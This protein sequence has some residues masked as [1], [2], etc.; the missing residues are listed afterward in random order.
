[1]SIDRMD[2]H[3]TEEYPSDL[4]YENS[5]THIGMYLAWIINN[6]LLSEDLE[7]DCAEE[8]QAVCNRTMTGRD[9]LIDVCDE[10]FLDDDLSEEGL[11]FT[12]SYYNDFDDNSRH[13]FEDYEDVLVKDLP[14]SYHVENTWEN[15]DL[16][17]PFIT[18]AYQNWKKK[19][20]N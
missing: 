2:W 8:A 11:N 10:K 3:Q 13:Y 20:E 14:S 5:G 7:E 1:M 18:K 19:Q 4:P 9:F 6:H 12:N 16:L 17:E 15:Y